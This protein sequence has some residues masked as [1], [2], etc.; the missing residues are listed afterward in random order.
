MSAALFLRLCSPAW[1]TPQGDMRPLHDPMR[2]VMEI[3]RDYVVLQY[4]T[5]TPIETRVQIRQS[6][7]PA[8]AWRPEGKRVDLWQGAGVR[9][10]QGEPGRRTYHR[11]RI[12]GLQPG[13]RYFYRIY[14]PDLQ[15]TPEER[16]WGANPP[17]RREYA[18]ATLAPAGYKTII[19]LPVKVL[20]MPNVVNIASAYQNPDNPAPPPAP[21]SDAELARIREEYA[22]AARYFWVNSGMRFWVDFQIF[23]DNRW[24]RWGDE[25]PQATGFYKGLPV[26]RSYPGVDFAPPG[27]GAFTIV[28]TANPLRTTAEP[29]FEEK[30]YAGQIEQAFPRRWN[31]QTQ[32]WEFYNSGGGTYGVDSF[33]DGVP[34]RS[35]FLGGGD[36]SWLV[37]H[38]FHH[39]ME[40]FGAFSLANREDERIVFNHP[41]PRYR[42][43]N[44]DG[45]VAMNAWN[46]A[47]RHG[48]H[49]NVMAYW[50]RTLSDAQWLRLY[51]GEVITVRDADGDGFPDDDPRLPLDEKRFGSNPRRATTD[52]QMN[53]LHK[54]MLST[55][56]PAPLQ[57]T[58][59]KPRWQSR[60]PDP[61]KTDQDGDGLP[62]A[63]DPYPLYP[64]QPF[65]WY[66][67]ATVDGD[68]SEWDA[69]PPAGELNADDTRL[70]VKHCHDGDAYYALFEITGE[71]ERLHMSFDIE[72]KGVYSTDS[73]LFVDIRNGSEVSL[74]VQG[75]DAPAWLQWK[76]S[77]R[78]DRTTVIELAVPNGG[79]SPWFW[80]GGGRELGVSID[81]YKPSG[82]GYSVYEPYDVFYCVMKEPIGALPLPSG[83]PPQLTREQATRV[84]T[85]Q[86]AEGL[87]IGAGWEVRN[88]AW[89]YDGHEESHLRISGLNAREFDLWVELEA[90]QDGILAAFLPSTRESEMNA[91]RDYILF[92]GGYANTRTRFRLFGAETSSAEQMMTPGRHTLQLSRRGGVL[93]A[94]FDGTPILYARDP[95]PSQPI[96]AL[97]V[98]GG[99][100]GKQRVYEIR[101]RVGEPAP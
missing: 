92:V 17:W 2:P 52:G 50:D 21:M 11:L 61:R 82:A 77:R 41:D 74:R 84:L 39:Q 100:S 80:M 83:A 8:A 46:T 93:W 40:S 101:Y 79:E 33:P 23:V 69:I 19:R 24:Q 99:Y 26:C 37:A 27:G 75:R 48:E 45:S 49:W 44:P 64:W 36:T 16:R 42:R 85:P 18:F 14:D 34:A 31:A 78:R 54:A 66:A 76:A 6:D 94:L 20:L 91:G 96:G 7:L 87:H 1:G 65:V 25:P 28:D 88:G 35:Q 30:P 3:G 86:N 97:A 59:V 38:E 63:I 15:P 53:D 13:K 60:T 10:V 68:P 98:I 90:V 32:R 62:D 12:S 67:R 89:A 4:H 22:I 95:N 81:L 5:R 43:K 70:T 58:F 55:W 71:W 56:A 47:G 9:T 51:F 72:G 57:F 29:V 73:V